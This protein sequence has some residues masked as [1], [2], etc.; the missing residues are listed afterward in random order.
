MDSDS[1]TPAPAKDKKKK[2][3]NK[4]KGKP[5][6]VQNANGDLVTSKEFILEKT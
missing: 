4:A 6:L 5:D 1:E 3:A 2:K